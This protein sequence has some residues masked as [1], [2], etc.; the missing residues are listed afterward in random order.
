MQLKPG[1]TATKEEV[2]NFLNGKIAKW[3]M[4]DDVAFV[5]N[6]PL[7]ATGKI[8]KLALRATFKDHVLP[9]R[10]DD[11]SCSFKAELE[12]RPAGRRSCA[13][14]LVAGDWR[15]LM[16]AA[17]TLYRMGL[18]VSPAAREGVQQAAM[19]A[20]LGAVALGVIGLCCR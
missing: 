14:R 8:N 3:W 4:P 11:G 20:M 5:D 7:G 12:R 1:A 13:W 10:L 16:F 19:W 2:L 18:V 15:R 17:P 9:R 6:I